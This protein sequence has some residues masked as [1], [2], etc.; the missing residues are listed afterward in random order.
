M[1]LVYGSW[2]SS[3]MAFTVFKCFMYI[4]IYIFLSTYL[5]VCYSVK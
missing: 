5:L 2:F 3:L 1:S 4:Y